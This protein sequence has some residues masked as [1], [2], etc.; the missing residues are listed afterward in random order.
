MKSPGERRIEVSG[1]SNSRQSVFF[2][3]RG[4]SESYQLVLDIIKFTGQNAVFKFAVR[5]DIAN[6]KEI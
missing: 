1:T 3:A 6:N 5:V 2:G 4:L